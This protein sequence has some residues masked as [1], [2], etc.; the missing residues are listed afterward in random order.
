VLLIAAVGLLALAVFMV[1]LLTM[2]H[3]EVVRSDYLPQQVA[4]VIVARGDGAQLY[5]DHVQGPIYTR[6][7]GGDHTGDLLFNH[8]PLTAVMN[9][10]ISGLDPVTGHLLWSVLQFVLVVIG[11][12]VVA[13]TAPWPTPA[14][15]VLPAAAIMVALAGAGTLPMLTEGQDLGT[16]TLGLG[17]CY[18]AWRRDHLGLGSAL[19]VAGAGIAKPHLAL[20][21]LAFLAGWRDRRVVVGALV[22]AVFIGALSLIAVGSTGT[23]AFVETA[24]R[25]NGLW[26]QAQLLGFTGL[27][28]TWFGEGLAANV[29][30][31]V[32]G[33]AALT[34]A[35]LVGAAVRRDRSRL[36]P[37]LV[38]A[39]LMSLVASPHMY[40]HDLVLL[41]PM[42]VL[43]LA[44]AAGRA[45]SLVSWPDRWSRA[46]L[47]WWLLLIAAAGADSAVA[48]PRF[49]GRLTPYAVLGAGFVAVRSV[50]VRRAVD[51]P[52][53][54]ISPPGGAHRR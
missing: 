48:L 52:E 16:I 26:P 38:G 8:A 13:L 44:H 54:L 42:L 19:L 21:L 10:P 29:V 39:T 49:L 27:F 31:D 6:L 17:L 15:R 46:V 18:A 25:S 20:G 9:A 14:L 30:A 45:R 53:R 5:S 2:G 24:I 40:S 34:V 32:C 50:A 3:S 11:C 41:A 47:A 37:A 7:A 28:A 22:G 12:V 4:G 43:A 1:R 33:V 35:F 51:S 36:G 23:V